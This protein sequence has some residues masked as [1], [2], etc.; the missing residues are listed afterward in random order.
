VSEWPFSQAHRPVIVAHRGASAECPENTLVAVERAILRGAD[1][2]EFDVR[3]T[4][5]GHGIVMHDDTVDRTTDGA[6]AVAEL[7]LDHLR[8]LRADGEPV[9]TAGEVLALLSGRCAAVIE[10]KH[11]PGDAGSGV[12]AADEALRALDVVGFEGPAVCISFDPVAL[13]HVRGVAP[14]RMTGLLASYEVAVADAAAAAVAGGHGFVLP[15]A[16]QVLAGGRAPVDGAHAAG[17]KVGTWV[18]DDPA[19]AITLAALDVDAIATN[20]PAAI[21][22]AMD[23]P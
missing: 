18:S 15:F 20:D 1:A 13:A 16:P 11:A 23:R 9:P 10:I 12:R 21:V 2:V 8:E 7:P 6:G 22:A 17:L 4:A 5:D 14:D 19:D 3:V